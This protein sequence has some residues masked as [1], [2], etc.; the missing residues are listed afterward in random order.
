MFGLRKRRERRKREADAYIKLRQ[1]GISEVGHTKEAK[2]LRDYKLRKKKR[3]GLG[4]LRKGDKSLA[5]SLFPGVTPEA[6]QRGEKVFMITELVQSKK[7]H[8][9]YQF[10]DLPGCGEPSFLKT[11][12]RQSKRHQRKNLGA[13]LQGMG[14][15]PAPYE[16]RVLE[17]KECAALCEVTLQ[18]RSIKWLRKL[19]NQQYRIHLTFDQL[20]ILMRSSKMN[21]AVRG[22][23][24]G[25]KAT[26]SY[27]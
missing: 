5:A 11:F 21:Y 9:P 13:R 12:E 27:K 16:M 22:Y 25:F 8:M 6:Y 7:T 4:V 3:K 15:N 23:P 2:A 17:D 19:I 24:I 26:Q 14:L 18:A 20:P 10:Y 1:A